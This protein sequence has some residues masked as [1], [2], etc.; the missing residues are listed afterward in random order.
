MNFLDLS[1]YIFILFFCIIYFVVPAKYKY[2]IVFLGSY[3][4]YLFNDFNLIFVVGG[5]TLLTY[6]GGFLINLKKSKIL[7]TIFVIANMAILFVYKY[8]EF[9]LQNIINFASFF[10]INNLCLSGFEFILPIGLSFMI[11]QSSTYLLDIYRKKITVENNIIRYAAFVAFFPTVLSGPIQKSRNLL[12]QLKNP[13]D[14]NYLDA[15][16]GTVLFI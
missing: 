14:F 2:L 13:K 6:F 12:P 1:F 5:I 15:K 10:G 4:F 7:L 3:F 16:K 11:F 9:I 8:L